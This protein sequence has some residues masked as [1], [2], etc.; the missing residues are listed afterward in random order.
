MVGSLG[1]LQTF[2]EWVS[3]EQMR[4]FAAAAGLSA[5]KGTKSRSVAWYQWI[6]DLVDIQ[7]VF[8]E[9]EDSISDRYKVL[10]GLFFAVKWN[11]GQQLIAGTS[12]GDLL[13]GATVKGLSMTRELSSTCCIKA[14][15]VLS[16]VDQPDHLLSVRSMD[17]YGELTLNLLN[18]RI[19]VEKTDGAYHRV[20]LFYLN[21]A[22][23][24][25]AIVVFGLGSLELLG[26]QFSTF[27]A[28]AAAGV[29]AVF[30]AINGF[31]GSL[32]PNASMLR[33]YLAGNF[34]LLSV[35]TNLLYT[36][37]YML[38]NEY[39]Q[40]VPSVADLTSG[41]TAGAC[42]SNQRRHAFLIVISFVQLLAV[43]FGSMASVN[44][45]DS[46]NNEAALESK[47][48]M[49]VYL[50]TRLFECKQFMH[51]KFPDIIALR[52]TELIDDDLEQLL[53]HG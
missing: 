42:E 18:A 46:V 48:L 12:I 50:R 31:L 34:W 26:G 8:G 37:V 47:M 33:G 43:L 6:K 25:L 20:V 52:R 4:R 23:F 36:E 27:V 35:L 11:Q 22:Q 53:G 17:Q 1:S 41:N 15:G 30:S 13:Q 16:D 51:E 32:G 45:L 29:V 5:G 38:N 28:T 24:G 40:C 9:E 2:D 10:T 14:S 7:S 19:K 3:S 49:L 44:L 21:I 39:M